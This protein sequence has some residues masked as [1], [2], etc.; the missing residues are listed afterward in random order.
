MADQKSLR[1]ELEAEKA[2]LQAAVDAY[3]ASAEQHRL[4]DE[5]D[6]TKRALREQ[7][8]L[9]KAEDD[10]GALGKQ[11]ARIDTVDGMVL[12]KR[13]D[14]IKV[15]RWQDQ[16]GDKITHDACREL[17]R[18]CVIY[19][20]LADFDVLVADRPVVMIAAASAVMQLAGLNTKALS[21][22]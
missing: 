17:A 19:P 12:V 2:A 18:P 11:I 16:H 3:E 8:A 22:K 15:R 20:E 5:L 6:E 10:H 1:D 4:Q 14:G 9:T 13:A 21:G 7:R